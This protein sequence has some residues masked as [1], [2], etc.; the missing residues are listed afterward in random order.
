MSV[1]STQNASIVAAEPRNSDS[2][3]GDIERQPQQ[4]EQPPPYSVFTTWQKRTL[5]LAASLSAFFS[6]LTAQIYLPALNSIADDLDITDSQ[7]NLTITTYMIFQGIIPMFVGSLADGGGRRPA[8]IVC[9]IV[10]IAANIGIALAPNFGAVLALRCLQSTG[11]S[12]TVAL[13]SAVVADVATSAE[14]G[15][16]IGITA[17]PAVLAPAL[18]PVIGGLLSQLLGWRSIFW[19]LTI[20]AGIAL[21]L[22]G[23]FFPETCRL[24][25]GDGSITPPPLYRTPLQA[26]RHARNKAKQSST[27]SL[28]SQPKFKFKVPNVLESILMLLQKETGVLLGTASITFAGFYSLAAAMP[29]QFGGRYGLNEIEVGLL[30]LPLAFGSIVAA[31][32]VGPLLG[33]NYRRHC[34]KLGLPF[35]RTRQL[36]LSE[37]PIERA[38]LEVGI[39]LIGLAGIALVAWGWA[40][41]AHAHLAVPVI[42]SSIL[43]VGMIGFNNAISV[44]LV[45]IHPGKAGTATAANNL[46]RC[47]LGAA[48]TALVV[49]MINGIGIGWTFVIL[50]GLNILCLP[51]VWLVM[52]KGMK[53]RTELRQ[54]QARTSQET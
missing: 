26:I 18:G 31:T 29:S 30:Y 45:D 32:V 4:E 40:V 41:D 11:S 16:Y 14:R 13:C 22:I 28:A 7:V 17:V 51:L 24:I 48:V 52:T 5:I 53:W 9:F 1:K 54:K 8:Y 46:T 12:P 37:F 34:A 2:G 21:V 35:D 38:R 19:F 23:L 3:E 10:Y 44:L 39:V 43:C 50:G 15:T 27:S 6:P 20:L 33:W 42:I 25:V 36:D 47:L 49:P